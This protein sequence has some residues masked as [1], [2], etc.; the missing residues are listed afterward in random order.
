MSVKTHRTQTNDFCHVAFLNFPDIYIFIYMLEYCFAFSLAHR[1][2]QKLQYP[3]VTP[4][5]PLCY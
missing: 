2:P 4:L 1:K 3:T 5:T